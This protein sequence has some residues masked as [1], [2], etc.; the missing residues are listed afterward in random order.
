MGIRK[1]GLVIDRV[2]VKAQDKKIRGKK[3]KKKAAGCL[4][5]VA[6][7]RWKREKWP[8]ASKPEAG[9]ENGVAENGFLTCQANFLISP[10]NPEK[11]II[12]R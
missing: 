11:L 8:E 2:P 7:K 1:L 5:P 3:E 4:L 6:G 10:F 9:W 12:L